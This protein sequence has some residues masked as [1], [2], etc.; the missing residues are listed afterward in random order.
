MQTCR[1]GRFPSLCFPTVIVLHRPKESLQTRT[2]RCDV[3]FT[4]RR[5]SKGAI[6][7]RVDEENCQVLMRAQRALTDAH[8]TVSA[9]IF[10]KTTMLALEP[11][12][13]RIPISWLSRLVSSWHDSTVQD[14][15]D[16]H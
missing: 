9:S 11:V 16:Y 6:T 12:M 14:I 8:G 10:S 5:P 13:L 15:A 2:L 7:V 3:V 1:V 4:T